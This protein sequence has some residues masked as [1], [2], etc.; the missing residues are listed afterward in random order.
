MA[1]DARCNWRASVPKAGRDHRERESGTEQNGSVEVAHIVKSYALDAQFAAVFE[2]LP[3]IVAKRDALWCYA[4]AGCLIGAESRQFALR[5]GSGL[6]THIKAA[7]LQRNAPFPC[8]VFALPD[9]TFE[10]CSPC[11]CHAPVRSPQK[12]VARPKN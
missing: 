12:T 4:F 9:I 10:I 11:Q 1:V 7:S 2:P 6:A 3:E 5:F 8:A